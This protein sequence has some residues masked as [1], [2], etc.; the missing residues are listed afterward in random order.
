MIRSQGE[1]ILDRQ[2]G[3]GFMSAAKGREAGPAREFTHMLCILIS[4]PGTGRAGK[5]TR[6]FHG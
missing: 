4:A 5:Q 1:R 2:E 6:T 3:W